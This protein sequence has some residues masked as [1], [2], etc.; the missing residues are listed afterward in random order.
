MRL[1]ILF[2][3]LFSIVGQAAATD[4]YV[5]TDGNNTNDGLTL[6]TSWATPSYAA[7][8]VNAGDTINLVNGTWYGEEIK[9]TNSGTSGNPITIKSYYGIATLNGMNPFKTPFLCGFD[10]TSSEFITI[11]NIKVFN[12]TNCVCTRYANNITILDSEFSHTSS[13]TVIISD[14][15]TSNMVL[16]NSSIHDSG[17]NAVQVIGNREIPAGTGVPSEYITITNN[18]MYHNYIHG[19]I[20]MFGNLDHVIIQNNTIRDMPNPAIYSH[21]ET[22]SQ[23][24]VTINSNTIYNVSDGIKLENFHDSNLSNNWIYGIDGADKLGIYLSFNSNNV[25][26]Y[27]NNVTTSDYSIY[28]HNS[29][30]TM[31]GNKLN[32]KLYYRI[33]SPSA[34]SITD[35]DNQNYAVLSQTG[36]NV[37]INYTDNTVFK[38]ISRSTFVNNIMSDIIYTPKNS[39]MSLSTYDSGLVV[40]QL[41]KYNSTV[42]PQTGNLQVVSIHENPYLDTYNITINSSLAENPTWINIAVANASSNYNI[43]KDGVFLTD[44]YSGTDSIVRYYYNIEGHEWDTEHTFTTTANASSGSTITASANQWTFYNNA[45]EN[46]TCENFCNAEDNITSL[47]MWNEISQRWDSYY[48]TWNWNKDAVIPAHR[49]VMAYFGYDTTIAT[50]TVTPSYYPFAEGYNMGAVQGS[51]NKT[52]A[53]M[54]TT[55]GANCTTIYAWDGTDWTDT[56]TTVLVPNEGWFADYN[57]T[58]NET[59]RTA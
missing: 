20:D 31:I 30:V 26:I 15:G 58:Y 45:T 51:D 53:E 11:Q 6:G 50:E 17:W 52:L 18:T 9:F 48:P 13:S 56:S 25:T 22:D 40:I 21:S 34:S 47:T 4:Y 55:F 3:V 19:G 39:E 33:T 59:E 29:N 24:N 12:Y 16:D 10:L 27:N 32:N 41:K 5:S 36:G 7:T 23:R 1:L 54:Q 43:I 14:L 8:Q 42:T 37:T 38:V 44:V 2:I 46:T 28:S 49:A 35:A 57:N